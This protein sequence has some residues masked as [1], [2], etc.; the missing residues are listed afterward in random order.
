MVTIFQTWPSVEQ[1]RTCTLSIFHINAVQH[2]LIKVLS[3]D[4]Y[5][6]IGITYINTSVNVL[7]CNQT[8]NRINGLSHMQPCFT[9][10]TLLKCARTHLLSVMLFFHSIVRHARIIYSLYVKVY[11][12]NTQFIFQIE[13]QNGFN[14][15][16]LVIFYFF[17]WI[18]RNYIVI[19]VFIYFKV[20]I[21]QNVKKFE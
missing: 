7:G 19:I 21:E 17:L 1:N 3:Y 20:K 4:T 15:T 14:V 10:R 16:F 8:C 6:G 11:A 2:C 12:L 13:F 5:T 9:L 18:F